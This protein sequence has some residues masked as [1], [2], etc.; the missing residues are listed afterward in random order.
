MDLANNR[1]ALHSYEI[2]DKFQ[3]GLVLTGAEVKSAKNGGITLKSA[4]IGLNYTP[5][6]EFF[7]IKAKISPYKFSAHKIDYDPERPR[8]ILLTSKEIQSLI[9]KLEQ[10]GLT[11]IPI[12]VYNNRNLVKVEIALCRGKKQFEKKESLKR[13]DVEKEIRARLKYQS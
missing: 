4:Y 1:F 7:L 13:K 3:A 11:I 12:R 10:K 8:K 6:P 5:K 9:G 2:L